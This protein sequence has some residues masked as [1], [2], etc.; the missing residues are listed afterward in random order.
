MS[1]SA[2]FAL[3][4][5][6]HSQHCRMLHRAGLH[7]APRSLARSTNVE[8]SYAALSRFFRAQGRQQSAWR[9]PIQPASGSSS[10]SI[11]SSRLA[12]WQLQRLSLA[13]SRSYATSSAPDRTEAID[14]K[15]RAEIT[16]DEKNGRDSAA[17]SSHGVPSSTPHPHDMHAHVSS[18]PRSLRR[19]AMSLPSSKLRRP[20]KEE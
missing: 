20:T 10:N 12:V 4:P 18:F 16:K 6:F 1:L 15:V 9:Q 17:S 3:V 11:S 2:H 8:H 14:E 13:T 5:T 19:L 7:A